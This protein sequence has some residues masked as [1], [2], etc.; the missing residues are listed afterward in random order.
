MSRMTARLATAALMLLAASAAQ[1]GD[2][3]PA[4]QETAALQAAPPAPRQPASAEVRATYDRTDALTRSV[5]WAQEQEINPADPVAG[6]KLAQA[7]R[8]LGRYDQ[9]ATTA[10]TTLTVQPAN[11]DAM[12]ELGRAH[13]ARGQ[14]FYG[15]AALERARD[16]APRDWRP[17]SL[18]GVAYEQVRRFDDA[19]AAWNQALSLSPDNPDVLTNAAMAAMTQGDAAGAEGLLRRAAAQP[20]ATAKIR[21]NLA[22]A[23]GLQ[24]KMGE[25]E[26]ILRR[27]LPPEQAERNLAWLRARAAGATAAAAPETARTWNSLQGG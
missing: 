12:L 18:L 23:L 22:M 20:G 21:Q 10:E 6:V 19:R 2:R 24:G 7:L 8:E 5:F 3:T 1:A 25:A 14:A 26:Q 17:W 11:L 9:A 4:P 15:I 27:E 13:I 16:Q